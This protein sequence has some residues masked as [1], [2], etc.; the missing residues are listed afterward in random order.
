MELD[1][2]D[3]DDPNDW[4]SKKNEGDIVSDNEN[5]KDNLSNKTVIVYTCLVNKKGEKIKK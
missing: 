2:S 5:S 1:K 4:G 3:I